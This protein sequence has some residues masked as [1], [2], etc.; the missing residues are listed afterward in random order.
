MSR[1]FFGCLLAVCTLQA[2]AEKSVQVVPDEAHQR[3][4]ITI[5]GKPF[6]SYVWPSSLK[7]PVLFPLIT[8]EGIDVVRGFPLAPRRG[9]RVDHPHHAGIWFNYGNVNNFDFWNNSDAIKPADRE[10]MGTI[11]QQ[12]ILST[13]S[14]D[15]GELFVESVWTAGNAQDLLEQK[16]RYIFSQHNDE[17]TIDL[18]VPLHDL[19]RVVFN[20]DKEGL[21]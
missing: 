17:R 6:T 9:E 5:D 14:G 11:H 12:K 18:I 8:S 20:D 4:D 10:K 3:V 13:K 16:T 21:L 2:V 19:D 15:R 1:W 7:K